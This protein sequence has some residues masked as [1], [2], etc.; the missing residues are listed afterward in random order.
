MVCNF[1]LIS[2][3]CHLKICWLKYKPF[4][5]GNECH[6]KRHGTERVDQHTNDTLFESTD[7]GK[8]LGMSFAGTYHD[9]LTEKNTFIKTHVKPQLT[10]ILYFQNRSH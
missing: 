1:H 10:K 6:L 5:K 4:S 8:K 3:F 7:M 2:Y 9:H